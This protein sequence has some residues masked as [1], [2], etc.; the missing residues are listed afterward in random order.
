MRY[1]QLRAFH[2]VATCGGFSRAADALRLTQPAISDQV[3]RLEAEFDVILFN[4]GKKQVVV[5]QT[6]ARLLEVTRRMFDTEQQAFDLLSHSSGGKRGLLRIIVDS[7]QHL[8]TILPAFTRAH[9]DV[10]ISLS[11]GN[12]AQVIEALHGYEADLGII[13][14]AQ[15]SNAF[16]YVDLSVTPIV[17]FVAR[18]HP[19]ASAGAVDFQTVA[20]HPLVLREEGSRTRARIEDAAAACGVTLRPAIEAQGREAVR[21]LVACGA[22]VGFVSA[23]EFGDDPRVVALPLAD[24]PHCTMVETLVCLRERS[25]SVLVAA[26]LAAARRSGISDGTLA[27]ALTSL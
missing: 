25:G 17:A 2:Y 7:A 9:P 26:F 3:R 6:G 19:L 21:E 24:A 5:T 11:T 18:T 8:R 20:R 16:E 15:P 10:R 22:G 4:R 13:G 27:S 23:A 14:D 12:T 1:V